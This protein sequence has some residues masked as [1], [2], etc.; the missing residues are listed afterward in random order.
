DRTHTLNL[1]GEMAGYVW[2]INNVAWTKDVPP[3]PVAA[4][5][6]VELFFVNP[7][8][9][10]HPLPPPGH[11]I[12]GGGNDRHRLARPRARPRAGPAPAPGRRRLRRQQSR[13][14]GA[15]LPSALPPR[16]RD[17]HHLALRLT[18]RSPLCNQGGTRES[19]FSRCP[20]ALQR[21]LQPRSP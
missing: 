21:G 18:G 1:T 15:P 20:S 17:V 13:A 4:G 12:Q 8:P 10:Q 5:G 19:N 9:V 14:L 16:V 2:S 11:E 6:R 7:T 3:L